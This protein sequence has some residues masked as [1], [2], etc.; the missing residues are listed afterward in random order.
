MKWQRGLYVALS[1]TG[2]LHH[3]EMAQ[4]EPLW[5]RSHRN[6]EAPVGPHDLCPP[7]GFSVPSTVCKKNFA[8]V[9]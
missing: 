9:W 5:G 8:R 4:A 2:P 3:P 7:C 6:Q 1:G